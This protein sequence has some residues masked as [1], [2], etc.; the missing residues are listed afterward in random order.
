MEARLVDP[1]EEVSF[2][3]DAGQVFFEEERRDFAAVGSEQN[4]GNDGV[5]RLESPTGLGVEELEVLQGTGQLLGS[6]AQSLG[7]VGDPPSFEESASFLEE[8]PGVT[9]FLALLPEL[10][11]EAVDEIS[12]EKAGRIDPVLKGPKE[13]FGL[14]E[15]AVEAESELV[16]GDIQIASPVKAFQEFSDVPGAASLRAG[17]VPSWVKRWPSMVWGASRKWS[18]PS[19]ISSGG[20]ILPKGS[21]SRI[22]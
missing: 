13:E 6:H 1:G 11:G 19:R 18:Q 8:A 4:L 14:T 15:V 3:D 21:A 20:M 10:D 22:L 16:K 2:G 17:Q 9:V 12:G 7:D 5:L